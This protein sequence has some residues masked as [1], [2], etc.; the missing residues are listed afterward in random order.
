MKTK[1]EQFLDALSARLQFGDKRTNRAVN[2]LLEDPDKAAEA[3]VKDWGSDTQMLHI[4]PPVKCGVC[5][6]PIN[7]N[8]HDT[9]GND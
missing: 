3:I 5:N 4:G 7:I 1:I 6:E 9:S 8:Q 2:K